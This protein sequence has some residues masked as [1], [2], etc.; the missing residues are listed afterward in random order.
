LL[1][2]LDLLRDRKI[3]RRTLVD[4]VPFL[5]ASLAFGFLALAARRSYE[6]ILMESRFGPVQDL[7]FGA[8]RL[9]FYYLARTLWPFAGRS[10][11]YPTL[12][13]A[14]SLV[15]PGLIPAALLALG[16]LGVIALAA[17][18][19]RSVAFGLA[20]FL[21]GL[22]PS[23]TL[24]NLGYSADRFSYLP[25]IGLALVAGLGAAFL[26]GRRRLW[27]WAVTAPVVA[28]LAVLSV[29]QC[30][31]WKDSVSLWTD[32]IASYPD[33]RDSDVNRAMAHISR[34]EAQAERQAWDPAVSDFTAA[35]R[36]RADIPDAWYGRA[37]A[38]E[39]AGRKDLALADLDHLLVLEP[40]HLEAII[41][42]AKLHYEHGDHAESLRLFLR[43]EKLGV[44]VS[45]ELLEF[46]RAR[47]GGAP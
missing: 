38:H 45:P 25:S 12:G 8:H 17:R 1:L 7:F 29:R 35:L 36:I 20:F 44:P 37:L 47:V 43:A 33:T 31:I 3:S 4:L 41:R 39:S 16:L 6:P 32:A 26:G 15:P 34:G 21:V 22:A 23:L 2:L 14:G 10:A 24:P 18:R 28:L 5:A 42:A 11:L 30:P 27:P 46:L 13:D 40:D 19:A 9:V